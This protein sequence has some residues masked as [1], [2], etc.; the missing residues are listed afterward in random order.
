[1]RLPLWYRMP[2]EVVDRVAS[3]VAEVVSQR[4]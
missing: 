4:S 2:A 1:L 3:A